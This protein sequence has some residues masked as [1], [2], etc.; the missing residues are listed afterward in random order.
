MNWLN[1]TQFA[2]ALLVVVPIL[3]RVLAV[4][5]IDVTKWPRLL[6]PL[7]ALFM[8]GLPVLVIQLEA[9][10]PIGQ[11]LLAA[12]LEGLG[13]I[14]LYHAAKRVKPAKPTQAKPQLADEPADE[15]APP[16]L[17]G[18]TAL[19]VLLALVAAGCAGSF[20]EARL[21]GL[22]ARSPGRLAAAP[23]SERCMA[24][25]D[26]HRWWDGV[27]KTTA[28][29][30]GAEGIS[31]WP[32]RSEKAE[33]YLAIGAGVTAAVAVGSEYLS[34]QAGETWARECSQ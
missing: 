3:I 5:K 14:G 32:V 28:V 29:L 19:L 26:E 13:A 21:A 7:P 11:A 22:Q 31:T 23:P 4:V 8:A 30:A 9:K 18:S 34:E 16:T 2:A 33:T 12:L 25:D 15:P 27:A 24:L 6:Q 10:A 1:S 17:R 20:E